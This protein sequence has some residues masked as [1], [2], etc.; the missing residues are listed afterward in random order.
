MICDRGLEREGESEGESE[1]ESERGRDRDD[2]KEKEIVRNESC[3]Y[4]AR[5]KVG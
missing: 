4:Q 5:K 2:G 1:S 3:V